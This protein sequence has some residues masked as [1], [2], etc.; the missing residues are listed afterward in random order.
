[1]FTVGLDYMRNSPDGNFGSQIFDNRCKDQC[2]KLRFYFVRDK[3]LKK[4]THSGCTPPKTVH[5][6]TEMCTLGAGCTLNF[7]QYIFD[8]IIYFHSITLYYVQL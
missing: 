7:G 1:M 5:L 6:A 2:L 4:R 8:I 3:Q